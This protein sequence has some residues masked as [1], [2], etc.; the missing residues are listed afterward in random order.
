MGQRTITGRSALCGFPRFSRRD[1]AK[2][3]TLYAFSRTLQ[4][5]NPVRNQ[6]L[7]YGRRFCTEMARS[8]L[9]KGAYGTAMHGATYGSGGHNDERTWL[10]G[11]RVDRG[12]RAPRGRGPATGAFAIHQGG[13]DGRGTGIVLGSS[14]QRP[15]SR[16][17]VRHQIQRY[18]EKNKRERR[19][20]Y[21]P[22]RELAAVCVSRQEQQ[23]DRILA[24]PV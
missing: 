20:P 9:Q 13:D 7:G 23:A 2:V 4:V 6:W 1:I 24:R 21:R 17:S 8:V 12:L 10:R 22:S 19:R 16:R 15:A 11:V 18:A 3:R 14:G 5:K